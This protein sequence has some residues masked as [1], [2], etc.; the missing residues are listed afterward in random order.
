MMHAFMPKG[1][2]QNIFLSIWRT[3]SA[4]SE[5]FTTFAS[6]YICNKF[7]TEA[8]Q[9]VKPRFFQNNFLNYQIKKWR[10]LHFVIYPKFVLTNQKYLI[11]TY[12]WFVFVGDCNLPNC[13]LVTIF[14]GPF[15]HVLEK[16]SRR[17]NYI[18]SLCIPPNSFFWLGIY[19]WD[20][21]PKH[22]ADCLLYFWFSF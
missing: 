15:V 13:V 4:F 10:C 2:C 19:C 8:A 12:T 14:G 17:H 7:L 22:T 16:K 11:C 9:V 3:H 20:S 18:C 6:K 21:F 1:I 5:W